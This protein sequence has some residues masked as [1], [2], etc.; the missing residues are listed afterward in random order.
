M[1]YIEMTTDEAIKLLRQSKTKT[2]I[3]SVNDLEKN[4]VSSFTQT[5][6]DECENI[7]LQARKISSI[8]DE[9]MKQLNCFTDKQNNFPLIEPKGKQHIIL[10]K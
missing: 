8:C 1:K 2:V 7:I 10:F 5:Q 9:F 4:E 6:K 3:V